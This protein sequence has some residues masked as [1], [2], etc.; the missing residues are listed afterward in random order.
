MSDTT[1]LK[2]TLTINYDLDGT[3]VDEMEENLRYMVHAATGNDL[4]T[5]DTPAAV[6]GHELEIE[7]VE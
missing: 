2:M 6:E 1:R 3:P 5:G 4:L 7:E